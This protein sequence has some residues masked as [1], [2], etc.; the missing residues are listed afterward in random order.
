[1]QVLR[2]GKIQ[3]GDEIKQGTVSPDSETM[4]EMVRAVKKKQR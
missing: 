3:A 1:M 4:T 2:E